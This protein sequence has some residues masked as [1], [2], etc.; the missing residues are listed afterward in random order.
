MLNA[1]MCRTIH[2]SA[3]FERFE[4]IVLAEEKTAGRRT[5]EGRGQLDWLKSK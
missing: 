2:S 1:R 3:A 4:Q 5:A